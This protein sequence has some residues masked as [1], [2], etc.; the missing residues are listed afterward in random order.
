[1]HGTR[2][3]FFQSPIYF[4]ITCKQL[5]DHIENRFAAKMKKLNQTLCCHVISNFHF[6]FPTAIGIN[7][8]EVQVLGNLP[9]KFNDSGRMGVSKLLEINQQKSP[10]CPE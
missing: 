1:M 8:L 4:I 10:L 3:L 5:F 6:S 7:I 9:P 2:M